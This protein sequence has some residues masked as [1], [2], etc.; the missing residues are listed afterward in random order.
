VS[1]LSNSLLYVRE[2]ATWNP[3]DKASTITLSGGNLTATMPNNAS[4]TRCTVRS[5]IGK[6]SGKWFYEIKL[7]SY[8]SS[9]NPA[10]FGCSNATQDIG[11][12]T[13]GYIG[14]STNSVGH[15]GAG[16]IKYNTS[17]LYT[18][19]A[20][21]TGTVIGIALDFDNSTTKWYTNGTLVFTWTSVISG[22]LFGAASNLSPYTHVVT[23][24]FGKT[25]FAYSVPAGYNAGLYR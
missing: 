20:M 21:T 15:Q 4:T 5:T 3:N 7:V 12:S 16:A 17:T 10:C 2:Y 8:S 14:G 23:A 6:S 1:A 24:N 22:T 25:P 13:G 9:P 11:P 19:A 18:D